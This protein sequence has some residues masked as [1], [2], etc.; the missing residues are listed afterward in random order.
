M[1]GNRSEYCACC[2]SR[3]EKIKKIHINTLNKSHSDIL[4]F[5]NKSHRKTHNKIINFGR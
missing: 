2:D 5:L 3:L 4:P 1:F